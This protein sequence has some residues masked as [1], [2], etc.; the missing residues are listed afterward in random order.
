MSKREIVF[1]MGQSGLR[2]DAVERRFD[3]IDRRLEGVIARLDTLIDAVADLRSDLR[4]H[5][6]DGHGGES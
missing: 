2:F 6:A 3:G 1:L 4:G 5:L